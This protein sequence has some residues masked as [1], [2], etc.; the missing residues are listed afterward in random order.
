MLR[1][2]LILPLALAAALEA[3]T[4]SVMVAGRV[5]GK[6]SRTAK[7]GAIETSYSYNDRGRGPDIR[8]R[9]QFDAG[10][11]PVAIDLVGVDYNKAP[12]DEHF[13]F[14]NGVGSWRSAAEHGES[15]MRGWYVAAGGSPAENGWLVRAMLRSGRAR[16]PL[17]PA[18]EA[19]LERGET[20]DLGARRVTL[21]SI[22]GLGFTPDSVWLDDAGE[23]FA[24][25]N[26]ILEGAEASLEKLHA[27]ERSAAEGRDHALAARLAHRPA[28]GLVIR[29]VRVFDAESATVREDQTVAIVGNRIQAAAPAGA[30]EVDGAGKM[31]LPGLFDMHAHFDPYQGLL[32]IASGVTTVRDLGNDMDDLLRVK[33]AMDAGETIGPR[34]V[35]AGVIDGRGPYAAPTKVLADTED[36]ARAYIDRYAAAGYTQI[37]IYSSVKPELVPFIARTAHAKGMRVSGH[38]PAGMVA[39]QFVDAGVDEMQHINFVFLNFMPAEAAKTNTRARLTAPAEHAAEINLDSPEVA[40]FIEKLRDKHIVVDPTL[41]VFE[42]Q[43][44]ARPGVP[45]PGLAAILDRLPTQERRGA[46]AG[47]LPAPGAQDALYRASFQA[48]LK[49]TARLYRAGVALV[50]GTDESDGLMLHREL[51]LWVAA[52]IPAERVLQTATWGAA[53]VARVS[54]ERGSIAPGK[55]ADLVLIDG[56]PVR[57]ISDVRKPVLTIKDGVV[58]RSHELYEAMGMR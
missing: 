32:D 15:R 37:K 30:E 39:D 12:I 48:F 29:H 42:H 2:R 43:Y 49:M 9:Y 11:M 31:L 54:D 1:L 27:A 4:Y 21:Y 52:G 7:A 26:L 16:M 53:R 10:G 28:K 13:A 47:G 50:I 23:L 18:G 6:E 46:L 34:V 35:L 41:G 20:L 25:G 22:S 5:A 57:R 33:R 24:A 3:Q 45:S 38:V 17:L 58:Y 8:S 19:V 44:T 14:E 56:D 40:R 36:E 51:E 55:L